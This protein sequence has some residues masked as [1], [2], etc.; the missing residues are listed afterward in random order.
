MRKNKKTTFTVAL[1]VLIAGLL[2]VII[3][4]LPKRGVDAPVVGEVVE[5]VETASESVDY[6]STV[7]GETKEVIEKP[8]ESVPQGRPIERD[9]FV[10]IDDVGNNLATLQNLLEISV[11]VTF[12]IMPGR[13]FSEESARLIKEAGFDMIL[14]QPMIAGYQPDF[15][16]CHRPEPL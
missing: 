4:V 12:A 3:G 11:P 1:L 6:D 14:H 10:I 5:E 15:L 13:P 16:P 8:I 9:I 2:G 7:T